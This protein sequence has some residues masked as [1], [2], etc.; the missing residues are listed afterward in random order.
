MRGEFEELYKKSTENLMFFAPTVRNV[1]TIGV[2]GAQIKNKYNI[3]KSQSGKV[4]LKNAGAPK[5]PK[6]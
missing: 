2:G 5:P 4:D 6:H 1:E 3:W